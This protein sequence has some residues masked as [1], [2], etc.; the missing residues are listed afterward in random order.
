MFGDIATDDHKWGQI[1]LIEVISKEKHSIKRG[2]F[3]G[4]IKKEIFV[5]DGFKIYEQKN[6]IRDDFK[7]GTYFIDESKYRELESFSIL[8]GDLIVSCSGTIGR[9]AIVPTTARHGIINQALL[10]LRLDK[11]KALP[12]FFKHLLETD[13]M[14][15]LIFG[16]AAGSAIKNVMPLS[17]I[18]KVRFPLPPLSLQEKFVQRVTGVFALEAEQAT[19]RYRLD[20]LFQ[21]M[22]HGGFNGEL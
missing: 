13:Y 15:N 12:L 17:Y 7:I 10:K 1:E 20:D 14:Q 19:S 3:G 18:K 6:A 22:L 4:A 9:V 21:S 2:P 11:A 16:G 8:P 5:P